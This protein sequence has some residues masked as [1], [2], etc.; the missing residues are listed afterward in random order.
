MRW[1]WI[2][3]GV[4]LALAALIS[5]PFVLTYVRMQGEEKQIF[6]VRS[7]IAATRIPSLE[8]F[9]HYMRTSGAPK[10]SM[11]AFESDFAQLPRERLTLFAF[12]SSPS[13]DA[14]AP[15]P[16]RGHQMAELIHAFKTTGSA[17]EDILPL[18][19]AIENFCAAFPV[20]KARFQLLAAGFDPKTEHMRSLLG[21]I[22]LWSL[23]DADSAKA[24]AGK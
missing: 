19:M 24:K 3:G 9:M 1:R 13:M 14:H 18:H 2:V 4:V 6:Q 23:N 10:E 8:D 12:V 11:A 20:S 16:L 17:D 22:K 5:I 7:G 21:F 15:T